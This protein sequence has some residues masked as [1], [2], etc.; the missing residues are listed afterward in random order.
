M[1]YPF[2]ARATTALLLVATA[3]CSSSDD[4]PTPAPATPGISWTVDNANL[5]S[6]SMQIQTAP[7]SYQV[8]AYYN[9]G[10][11]NSNYISLTIPKTVGTYTFS[12]T[13][14]AG[15]LYSVLTNNV[16]T[17][18]YYAGA[19][20]SGNG[21]VIGAGTIVVTEATTSQVAGTFTFTGIDR[22]TGNAKSLSNGKFLIRVQ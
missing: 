21:T 17:A 19:N 14:T 3:A 12:P 4:E 18:V 20:P 7:D 9:L 2:L 16:A 15:A 5:T 1:T 11:V 13:A 8:G 6:S 10:G 22:D